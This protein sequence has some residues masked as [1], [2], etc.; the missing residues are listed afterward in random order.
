MPR[1]VGGRPGAHHRAAHLHRRV[2]RRAPGLLGE[3]PTGAGHAYSPL[4]HTGQY[5]EHEDGLLHRTP[6]SSE[7]EPVPH[8]G[9][10]VAGD[11]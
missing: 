4:S 8:G 9:Q 2:R 10:G 1:A 3:D 7:E 6:T 11:A 5:A